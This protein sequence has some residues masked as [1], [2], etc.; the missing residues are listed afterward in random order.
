MATFLS[1]A[2]GLETPAVPPRPYLVDVVDREEWGAE[3]PQGAFITHTIERITV[4][5]AG[6]LRGVTGPQQFR[7]W[8]SWH[9]Y[10]G[11]PDLAY[12]FIVGRDGKVY[13][14]RP[15]QAVG[16]TATEYD[17]AGHFLIVVEGNFDESDPTAAQLEMLAQMVA[18]ASLQ[19]DVP[20]ATTTGHRD[21]AATSC[22]GDSLHAKIEDGSIAARAVAIL[23]EGGVTVSFGG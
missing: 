8:Q 10:L 13:E 19:F 17:P 14:G 5:H 1:R 20:V 3:D 22:P 12:H 16:D 18:W 11:W 2:L 23:E 4:H 9:H 6:S 15:Y 7:S 21:H